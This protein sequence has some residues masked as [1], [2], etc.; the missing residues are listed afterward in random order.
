MPFAI[1]DLN[2][3][4]MNHDSQLNEKSILMMQQEL[5]LK[6]QSK[7]MAQLQSKVTSDEFIMGGG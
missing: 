5:A 6:S 4:L 2:D 3:H 7:F 1:D